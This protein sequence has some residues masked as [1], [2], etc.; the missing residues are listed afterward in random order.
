MTI[1]VDEFPQGWGKWTG[2]GHMLCTDIDELHAMARKI[3]LKREWFQDK[4]Y[5][6]YDVQRR[7]RQLAIAAGAQVIEVGEIPDDVLMRCGDGT[8]ERRSNLMARLEAKKEQRAG[9]Q[10]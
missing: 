8:Y 3:G 9:S 1:Y 5:P 4:R 10:D 2:G 6:H 7:K